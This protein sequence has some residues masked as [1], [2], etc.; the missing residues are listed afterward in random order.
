[1]IALLLVACTVMPYRRP[2]DTALTGPT[3]VATAAEAGAGTQDVS[4]LLSRVDALLALAEHVDERDRLVE[5]RELVLGAGTGDLAT[6]TRVM[7]YVERVVSIEERGVAQ[8]IAEPPLADTVARVTL[9]EE[10]VL[11][12]SVAAPSAPV[13]EAD[14]LRAASAAA[15]EGK[16][17][18]ALSLLEAEGTGDGEPRAALMKRCID[19]WAG[20]E[21]EAAAADFIRASQLPAGPEREAAMAG[22]KARLEAVNTRFPDNA[23]AEDVRRHLA[24]VMASGSQP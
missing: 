21:R 13:K 22:V 9:V 18:L 7:R 2:P 16:W 5:L 6:R 14:P 20:S 4:G 8:S 11:E 12:P 24:T 3:P 19:G 17:S 23:F 10:E 1:V 15:G